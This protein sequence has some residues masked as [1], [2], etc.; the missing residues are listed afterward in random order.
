MELMQYNK[1]TGSLKNW[2][3]EESAFDSRYLGK[4][5]AIFAL[6]NGYIGQRAALGG[7][8]RRRDQRAVCD[9]YLQ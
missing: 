1:G 7:T 2:L 9:R 3:V 4:C 6:G 8:L 5:E